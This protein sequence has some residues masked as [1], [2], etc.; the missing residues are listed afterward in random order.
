MRQQ[1]SVSTLV[2]A[3]CYDFLFT[4][5]VWIRKLGLDGRSPYPTKRAGKRPLFNCLN[6]Y[7]NSF[8]LLLL[9]SQFGIAH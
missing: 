7:A 9:V 8:C 6:V 1:T 5:F 2:F 3:T 4:L